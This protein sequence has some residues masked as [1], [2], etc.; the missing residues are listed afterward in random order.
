MLKI[1]H[2][3]LPFLLIL[4]LLIVV[5]KS[6]LVAYG[7]KN[8]FREDSTK[9]RIENMKV[10]KMVMHPSHVTLKKHSFQGILV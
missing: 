7:G 4:A 1:A 5:V 9:G 10:D 2:H 8:I 3:F 6:F